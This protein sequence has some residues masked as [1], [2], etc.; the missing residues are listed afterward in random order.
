MVEVSVNKSALK[1]VQD[2]IDNADL[3]KSKVHKLSNGATVIDMGIEVTGGYLAGVKLGEVCL[4]GLGVVNLTTTNFGEFFV[5][6]VTVATDY[7]HIAC[8]GSQFA[9]WRLNVKDEKYF[10][11]LS[12][13]AR[14]LKGGEKGLFDELE[15]K[16]NADVAIAVLEGNVLPNEKVME[17]IATKCKVNVDKTYALIAPTK[18]MAGAVQIAAR[19]VE[20]GIH[21]LHEVGYDPKKIL[22]GI[23][24]TPIAPLA[25]SDT[26][27]MGVTNDAIIAAGSVI[28]NIKSEEGDNLEEAVKK[29]P[30]STS[31]QYGKPFYQIFVDAGK[32]FYNIDPLLFAPAQITVNDIRTGTTIMAGK[33]D[34]ELLKSSFGI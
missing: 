1:V 6:S 27:A 12:G 32:D 23:G 22:Y 2:V 29:V 10:A 5:P 24:S 7:P 30:S 18:S 33:L 17:F 19:V 4:G 34:I 28:Y 3:Y 8:L 13:P 16:D 21:K 15:Y 31:K 20:M 25:K 11:M 26:K 9:G 14:A